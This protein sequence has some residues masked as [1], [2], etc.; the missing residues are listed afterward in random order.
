MYSYAF[1][2]SKGTYEKLKNLERIN[3]GLKLAE[4]DLKLRGEGD[5]TGKLQ[6]GT[7]TFKFADFS[8]LKLIEK[9]REEA[10]NY[11]ENITKNSKLH[12]KI[13]ESQITWNN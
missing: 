5:I 9:V 7:K 2:F 11:S 12:S 1:T 8:N 3:D 10:K 13:D 6:S 4:L